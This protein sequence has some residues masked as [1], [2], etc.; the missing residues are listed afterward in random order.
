MNDPDKH[1]SA[2]PLTLSMLTSEGVYKLVCLIER[3]LRWSMKAVIRPNLF[4]FRCLFWG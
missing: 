3:I 4:L 1:S 2:T